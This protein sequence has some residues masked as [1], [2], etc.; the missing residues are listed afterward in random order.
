MTDVYLTEQ[1]IYDKIVEHFAAQREPAV[2]SDTEVLCRYRTSN[3]LKC[4]IG[5]LIPDEVYTAD[6][7]ERG[8][9]GLFNEFKGSMRLAG[10]HPDN[11]TLLRLLQMAH[12][13]TV[14]ALR[15]REYAN[16]LPELA[17]QLRDV[18]AEFGL[19]PASL[20]RLKDAQ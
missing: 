20:E 1:E 9:Q 2:E 5:A 10:L 19:D 12:D 14:N 7:E 13:R 18:A 3:G 16:F 8:V 4:A 15:D 11:T 17:E 6:M